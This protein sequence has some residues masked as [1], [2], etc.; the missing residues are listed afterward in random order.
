MSFKLKHI[1]HAA[2]FLVLLENQFLSISTPVN[3]NVQRIVLV[4][5]DKYN[6]MTLSDYKFLLAYHSESGIN[7]SFFNT[8][9]FLGQFSN[10][11]E[12]YEGYGKGSSYKSWLWWLTEKIFGKNGQMELLNNAAEEVSKQITLSEVK[13]IVM[14]PRPFTNLTLEERYEN[15][16]AYVTKTIQLFNE[17]NYSKLKLIGFYW[18]CETV[19]S[20]DYELVRGVSRLVHLLG[21]KFYWIPYFGAEGVDK[22]QELG[23]DYVMLQPNFA[24][25]NVDTNRFSTVN[26][27]AKKLNTSVEMELATFVYNPKVTWQESFVLYMYYSSL[28]NW[29]DFPILSYFNGNQFS[30]NLFKNY[31]AYYDLV[32]MHVKGKDLKNNKIVVEGYNAHMTKVTISNLFQML[33]LF[34]L[35]AVVVFMLFARMK[36]KAPTQQIQ[37]K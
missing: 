13:I 31:R 8:F 28:Y 11:N 24:F 3:N 37:N 22:W 33:I 2:T 25:S 14:I 12:S 18:M 23:F 1:F 9:L 27:I 16:K 30:Q 21:L 4:Y 34:S 15:V 5:V 32:Y 35:F 19:P 7:D 36:L 6:N 26:E 10:T 20:Q 29:Q 17:G